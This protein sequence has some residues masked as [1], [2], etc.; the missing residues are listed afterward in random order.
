MMM[1]FTDFVHRHQLK[2]EATSNI[3]IYQVISSLSL[4]D[5]G[6]YL[7][8]GPIKSDTGIVNL[9]PSKGTL[10]VVYTTKTI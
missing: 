6:I 2:N 9:Q 10:R 7:R 1:S 8:D 4:S 5:V 3:K